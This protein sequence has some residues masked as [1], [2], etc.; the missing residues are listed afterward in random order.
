MMNGPNEKKEMNMKKGDI[1]RST[2]DRAWKARIV[3]PS[4]YGHRIVWLTGPLKGRDANVARGG[5]KR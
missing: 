1:V 4:K 3:G 5:L 2:R